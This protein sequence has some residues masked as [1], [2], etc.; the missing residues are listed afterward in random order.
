MGIG[1]KDNRSKN[2]DKDSGT[3]YVVSTPIGNLEDITLRALDILKNVDLIAAENTRHTRILCDHYGIINPLKSYNQHNRKSRAPELIAKLEAGSD[4][5]LVTNAGTPAISDPGAMLISMAHDREIKVS[6]IPGPSAV[7]AALSV[8]GLRVDR[9]LFLGFLSSRPGKRKKEIR[10]LINEERTM[11]FYEAPHRIES[12][13]KDLNEILGDRRVVILREL[14]KIYEEVV[15]G[16]ISSILN[17]FE[18]RKIQGEFTIVLAG[19]EKVKKDSSPDREIK[20]MIRGFLKQGD[21]T[22]KDIA[23]KISQESDYS[24]RTIYRECLALK[25][26]TGLT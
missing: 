14:T 19:S 6:P 5:A 9:F 21:M 13:L 15:Q 24:Y 22:V 11:I 25:K 26:E 17:K 10:D 20:D 1:K 18:T 8:C 23:I 16:D 12:M 3:L 2:A 4:I 7:I